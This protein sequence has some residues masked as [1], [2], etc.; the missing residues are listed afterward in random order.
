MNEITNY[1]LNNAIINDY[2]SKVESSIKD[3]F[4]QHIYLIIFEMIESQP[5]KIQ[6]LYSKNELG[7][8][9]I[10]IINNQLKSNTSS[11]Y[12][13]FKKQLDIDFYSYS[14][15]NAE[16]DPIFDIVKKMNHSNVLLKLKG[17]HPYH[18]SLFKLKWVDGLTIKEISDKLKIKYTTV[19]ASIK[20][21]EKKLKK[22][23]WQND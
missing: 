1:I 8:F 12:K 6:L 10:G 2:F 17:F 11:F 13:Q 19:Y 22:I 7:K 9:I 16:E 4:K 21:T 14:L 23:K 18:L 20:K 5:E 3:D 15:I